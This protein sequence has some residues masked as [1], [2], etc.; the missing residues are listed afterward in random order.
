M[1]GVLHWSVVQ[2]PLKIQEKQKGITVELLWKILS[3][4]PGTSS[5][6][7]TFPKIAWTWSSHV[8]VIAETALNQTS[9]SPLAF[10]LPIP[11]RSFRSPSHTCLLLVL[12]PL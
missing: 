8:T 3:W 11:S 9:H 7:M 2:S 4:K 6:S 5:S 12:I 1:P 10:I